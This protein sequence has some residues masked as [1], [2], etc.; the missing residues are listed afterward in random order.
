LPAAVGSRIGRPDQPL[1]LVTGDGSI[2]MTIQELATLREQDLAFKILILNNYSLGMVRQLQ[3]FYCDRRYTA[4][5]FTFHPDFE[6]LAK[7]YGMEGYT[8]KSEQEV[9]E[10]LGGILAAPGPAIINCLVDAAENVSPMVLTGKGI[11][12]AIE[13]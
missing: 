12:E 11:D 13:C 8:L 7:A 9:L 2:Q 5:N 10:R 3:E 4:T 1:I 6:Y